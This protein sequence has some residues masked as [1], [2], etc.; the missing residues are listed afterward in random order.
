MA[1]LIGIADVSPTSIRSRIL[2]V[3]A[4]EAQDTIAG[5]FT[6]VDPFEDTESE[7]Y[8]KCRR[9]S[10]KGFTH[11]DPFEDT[12]STVNIHIIASI[13]VSPTSIRS[14]ILKEA[15]NGMGSILRKFVSPTSIRSRILKGATDRCNAHAR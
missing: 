8:Y 10:Q 9:L 12:E 2:K 4:L 5:R 3:A 6:H 13:I 14:R 7:W 11:V 15:S 1:R